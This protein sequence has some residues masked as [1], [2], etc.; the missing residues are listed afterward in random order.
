MCL[1]CLL[2]SI[3]TFHIVNKTSHKLTQKYLLFLKTDTGQNTHFKLVSSPMKITCAT[4]HAT[5]IK[6]S[7]NPSTKQLKESNVSGYQKLR[8]NNISLHK[9][10]S[11][12]ANI[13]TKHLPQCWVN[14]TF[15]YVLHNLC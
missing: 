2:H 6:Y 11:W 4:K 5:N 10:C 13:I 15:C 14:G 1:T 12:P 8:D 9:R 7:I 3:N